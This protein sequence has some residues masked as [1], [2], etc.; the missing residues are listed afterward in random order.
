M[1]Y[2]NMNNIFINLTNHPSSKWSD[3]QVNAAKKLF[4]YGDSDVEIVDI[5]FPQIDP[6][7]GSNQ[8]H[9]LVNEYVSKIADYTLKYVNC[10]VHVM[11]EMTFTYNIVK[12]LMNNGIVCVA[13]TTDR[14]VEEDE[15]GVKKSIFKF[16]QFRKY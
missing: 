7:I 12:E 8:I 5:P 1:E 6:N 9:E 4:C 10:I 14:I 15:N 2:N 11:G 3:E 13:S 16:N